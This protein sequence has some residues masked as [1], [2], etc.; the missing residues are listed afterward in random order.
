M[1]DNALTIFTVSYLRLVKECNEV[2]FE[3]TASGSVEMA[4]LD[5]MRHVDRLGIHTA[6]KTL[7]LSEDQQIRD[8]IGRNPRLV[9]NDYTLPYDNNTDRDKIRMT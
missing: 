3:L 1:T 8:Y 4:V 9:D 2:M 7:V 6:N 5:I